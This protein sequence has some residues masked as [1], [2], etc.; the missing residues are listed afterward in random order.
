MLGK[1]QA[2]HFPAV[3]GADGAQPLDERVVRDGFAA[4]AAQVGDG[5]S[6]QQVAEGFLRIAVENMANAIK[7]ISVQRGRDIAGYALCSFGGAGGQHACLVADRLGIN[8]VFLHPFAGVLSAY[9]IGLAD[10]RVMR[11]KALEQPLTE[12][13]AAKLDAEFAALEA[14]AGEA[15]ADDQALIRSTTLLR[16]AHLRYQGSDTALAV[17]AGSVEAM[18][19]AFETAHRQRFGFVAADRALIVELVEVEA[20][21][22]GETADDPVLPMSE[23]PPEALTAISMWSGGRF[24][25]TVVYDRA[26][27]LPGHRLAGPAILIED[28][29]TTVVEPDWQAAVTAKNHL[30]LTRRV[31]RPQTVDVSTQADPMMLEIFNS[32]FMAIADQMGAVL[33][34]TAHSVNIKER[35]DFSCAVFDGQ[36]ELVANAPHVPV[37]LGSM[38]ESVKA[39]MQARAGGMRPGEVYMMNA[40]YNGGTH[41]PDI[42]VVT[43][44]FDAAGSSILFYVASRGHHADIGGITPGSMPPHSRDASEEGIVIDDFLLVADDRFQEAAVREILAD[45]PYPARLPDQNVADL[46]AQ[47]A[48]NEKGAQE[49]RR[50][51]E[52]FGLAVVH[53]YMRHVQDNAAQAVRDVLAVLRDGSFT[54]EMDDGSVIA[55]AIRIDHAARRAVVDF[56]GTSGQRRNNFNAPSAICKACVLYV[57]RTLVEQPIPLNAGCLRPLEIIIPA[58]SM[59][60]PRPPAAVVAGNVETSQAIVDALYGA[61]GVM[62]AGQGTMNNFTFGNDRYQYYETIAGGSG[63]GDGF[64]GTAAVQVNMT[65][66]RLTDPEVLEWRFPVRVE[67]FEIRTGSGGRGRYPGGDG[68][69]RRIRFNQPMTAAILSNRRR[70]APFGMMGGEDGKPG[71]NRVERVG[72]TIEDLGYTAC[73]DMAEGDVFVIETPGGGGYGKA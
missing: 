70:T 69:I 45:G 68:V 72:G 14:Q 13:L 40:P 71:S 12:A 16:R 19:S 10:L 39:I 2:R 41:L 42:T 46:K 44:V 65:N 7:T 51:V 66:S 53:A 38:G 29:G 57:F 23:T 48:A 30:L 31:P 27:M 43:P 50:M 8:T 4:L 55:V 15:L 25:D 21:G 9:G 34:N 5:R 64:P 73:T 18:R 17:P 56:T 20:V 26:K 37:H 36:G 3:F 67:S 59:L 1:L 32:L 61:L 52:H 33:Q 47:V 11:E 62:A 24:H 60:D 63:A 54:T 49:L 22:I 28:T 35:L 6:P 58:G